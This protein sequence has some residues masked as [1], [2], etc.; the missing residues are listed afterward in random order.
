VTQRLGDLPRVH[1]VTNDEVLSRDGWVG[2]ATSVLEAGGPAVALHLRAP[3][4]DGRSIFQ[5][6]IDLLPVAE[7]MKSWLVVN[8]RV[9]VGMAAGL[10]AIHLG[11]R[12]LPLKVV[13]R[14]VA[15]GVQLG[16]SGHSVKD[17]TE[18]RRGG[19]DYA[20]VGTV[21]P[22]A[23]HPG[24]EGMGLDALERVSEGAED[25]PLVGIGGIDVE[26]AGSVIAAGAHGV[27]AIG[28][29]WNEPSPA[30]AVRG[31][32]EAVEAASFGVANEMRREA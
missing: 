19:A 21:F 8:D 30:V 3:R 5:M 31:Y 22:S 27:A 14:L 10:G 28:G 2:A 17:A 4:G 6:I 26:R 13:R 12:S 20:F 1:V 29:I 24:V 7:R 11:G 15:E 32:I 9:D 25:W 16:V 18:A 23:S